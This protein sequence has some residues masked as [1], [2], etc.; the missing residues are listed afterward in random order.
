MNPR[1]TAENEKFDSSDSLSLFESYDG[2][3]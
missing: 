2:M 3:G 1:I